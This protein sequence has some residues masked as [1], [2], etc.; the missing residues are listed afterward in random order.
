MW[1]FE[2]INNVTHAQEACGDFLRMLRSGLRRDV[3]GQGHDPVVGLYVNSGHGTCSLLAG[4]QRCF[5]LGSYRN[6][7][8]PV[9]R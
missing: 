8:R 3:A 1:I 6:V 5:G 9:P 7:I 4:R 2:I